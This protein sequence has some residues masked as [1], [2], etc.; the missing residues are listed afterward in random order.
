MSTLLIKNLHT[1]VTCDDRDS[2]IHQVDL[3]CKDGWIADIGPPSA[4][5][6]RHCD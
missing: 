3:L 4:R 5:Y 6:R 2:I 1:L